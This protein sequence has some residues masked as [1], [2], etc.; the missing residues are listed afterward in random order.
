MAHRFRLCR[1]TRK[2]LLALRRAIYRLFLGQGHYDWEFTDLTFSELRKRDILPIAD[3]CDFGVPDWIGN[4]QNP[5]FPRIFAEYAAA[6][7][8]RFPWIQLYTLVN[9]MFI[10]AVFSAKYGWWNEQLQS[11]RALVNALKHIVKANVMAMQ[12]ILRVRSD[13]LFIQSESSEYFHAENPHAIKP[14]EL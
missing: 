6:F 9:E 5:D 13:A 8:R 4:F 14:A 7:A 10:C 12:E 1:R 11:D 3:L 2:P